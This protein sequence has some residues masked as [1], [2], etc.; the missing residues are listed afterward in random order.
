V[1]L[2]ASGGLFAGTSA[3]R[4]GA[5]DNPAPGHDRSTAG[6]VQGMLFL[7]GYFVSHKDPLFPAFTDISHLVVDRGLLES[8]RTCTWRSPSRNHVLTVVPTAPLGNDLFVMRINTFVLGT[9]WGNGLSSEASG[10]CDRRALHRHKR[11]WMRGCL[12]RGLHS[13]EEGRERFCA[14]T[15]HR[16]PEVHRLWR[17]R[18]GW[19]GLRNLCTRRPAPQWSRFAQINQE[20]Y[21]ISFSALTHNGMGALDTEAGKPGCW[22]RNCS[23]FW[24]GRRTPRSR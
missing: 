7:G 13:S 18:A 21:R 1:Y 16:S 24:R 12:P 2:A 6:A 9:R 3:R 22:K 17:L 8:K 15:I 10:L 23:H 14:T 5:I 19:S 4:A 20:H 11:H